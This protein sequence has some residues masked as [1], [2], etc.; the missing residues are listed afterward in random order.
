MALL[1]QMS[2]GLLLPAPLLRGIARKASHAYKEYQIP[3]RAGGQRT[4]H[5]PSKE[6]KAL[7]RWLVHNVVSA[8]PMHGAAY[9]YR[10]G[11]NIRDNA[12]QHATSNYLLRL[13]LRH[14]QVL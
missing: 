13:D 9:A 3:K 7:Q 10:V 8:W 14:F 2:A 12:A 1:D 5:H 11:R 6:L 4:I